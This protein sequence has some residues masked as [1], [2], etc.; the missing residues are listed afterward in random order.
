MTAAARL[1]DNAP[2]P[3]DAIAALNRVIAGTTAV[4]RSW[5]S[6]FLAG[7]E[8]ANPAA[9]TAAPPAVK[10]PL[11]ILFATESGNSEALA[12]KA[13]KDAARLGFAP[14]AVRRTAPVAAVRRRLGQVE[15][16]PVADHVVRRGRSPQPRRASRLATTL[17]L[18][19]A[20]P[21]PAT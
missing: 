5:L 7:I 9:A 2:F 8:A 16:R 12:A 3:A 6:G 13:K 14:L 17:P 10:Q 1:P 20:E 4:Q 18:G 21:D 15:A 19:P 11:T